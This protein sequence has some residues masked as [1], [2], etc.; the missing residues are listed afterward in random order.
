MSKVKTP[1]L[2]SHIRVTSKVTYEVL[3][4]DTF[5]DESVVGEMRKDARQIVIKNGQSN[6]EL[7]STYIHEVL[8]VLSDENDVKLTESQ[9]GKLELAIYRFLRLN[10]I[11]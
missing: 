7:I 5:K 3:F 1:I 9:V 6:K 4:T 11:L 8:H 10:G 2:P